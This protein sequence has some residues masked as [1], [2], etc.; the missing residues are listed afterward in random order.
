MSPRALAERV[1]ELLSDREDVSEKNMFGSIC[2]LVAGNLAVCVREEELL[3]RLDPENAELATSERGVR[4]AE[5][6]SRRMKGWVFVEP[7]RLSSDA[8]LE[9]W[10]DAGAD[11]A[12]SLP[13]KE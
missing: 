12:A 3:V 10:V 8:E 2:F 6:G 9:D 7:E 1:R 4:A 11:R 5:M 13:A